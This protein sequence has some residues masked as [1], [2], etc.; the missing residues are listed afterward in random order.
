MI[1]LGDKVKDKVTGLVGIAVSKI[2]YLNG[3]VQY[4][5]SPKVKKDSTEL[6]T[7]NIDE[8]QLESLEKKR[9]KI[10]KSPTGGPTRRA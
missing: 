6:L 8:E 7:W 3:C 2:E 4:G 10:K 5:V 9:V 1:N